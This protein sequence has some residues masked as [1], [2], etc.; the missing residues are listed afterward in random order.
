M[1][2]IQQSTVSDELRSVSFGQSVEREKDFPATSPSQ[3][4][5]SIASPSSGLGS[6][7]ENN[8][9]SDASLSSNISAVASTP[10]VSE[11]DNVPEKAV[12]P[13]V[14]VLGQEN[15]DLAK[16]LIH[17]ACENTTLVN[18]FYWYLVIECEDHDVGVKQDPRARE[19][20]K[21][22]MRKFIQVRYMFYKT[23]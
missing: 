23:A 5:S 8:S 14:D 20:Y 12:H 13:P 17:R 4:A 1:K 21:I 7:S 15:L 2:E 3:I 6:A 9:N 11:S 19:M 10:A 16:F 22:V 18:Y